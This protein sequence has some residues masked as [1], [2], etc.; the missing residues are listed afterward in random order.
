MRLLTH[1]TLRNNSADAKGKGF[2]LHI[3]VSEVRIDEQNTN[4][5]RSPIGEQQIAFVRGILPILD[6]AALIKA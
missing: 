2:P 5:S 6:W 3:A 4:H 1:N